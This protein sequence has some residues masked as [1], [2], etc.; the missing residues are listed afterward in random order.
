MFVVSAQDQINNMV[1]ESNDLVMDGERSG[2]PSNKIS[3]I[4]TGDALM[5]KREGVVKQ[6]TFYSDVAGQL[7]VFQV[8]RSDTQAGQ[9]R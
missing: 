9:G 1:T 3:Y 5:V 7:V 2:S 6:W 4:G 8:W